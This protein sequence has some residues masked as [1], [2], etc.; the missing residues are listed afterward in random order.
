MD[1]FGA[2]DRTGSS[3]PEEN[4]N[5]APTD[6]VIGVVDRHPRDDEGS[7]DPSRVERSLRVF[8]WGL[9]PHW[10]KDAK[11]GAKMINARAE[12][13]LEK[14]AYKS[15]VVSRRCV[16]PADGWYEWRAD[17]DERG[18]VI[19]R[20]YFMT[21]TDG[22]SLAM[23]GIWSSWRDPASG[24]LV[25]SAAVLTTAATDA[26]AEIHE[27][28]PL[29]LERDSLA[30]WLDP[31]SAEVTELLHRPDTG[32]ASLLETRPVGTEVNS[33]RNNGPALLNRREPATAATLFEQS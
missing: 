25:V 6:P 3:A 23:A 26:L 7:A 13:V 20:P 1:E 11:S 9:I 24:E 4:Y 2:V 29:V 31:D 19:K 30:H 32:Y 33:V 10:A 22:R 16:L 27:R 18:K 21:R 17:L 8:R 15:S 12:T 5:I 14:A 28:M